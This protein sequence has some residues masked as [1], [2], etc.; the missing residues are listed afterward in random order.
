MIIK[1]KEEG[2]HK[3]NHMVAYFNHLRLRTTMN[4]VGN[5][6]FFNGGDA[7]GSELLRKFFHVLMCLSFIDIANIDALCD[8]AGNNISIFLYLMHGKE[9][10]IH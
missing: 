7:S 6:Y 2:M 1:D 10:N 8:K 9:Q 5:L 3:G 4:E